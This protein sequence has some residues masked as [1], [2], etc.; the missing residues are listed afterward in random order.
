MCLPLK[1]TSPREV[2]REIKDLQKGKAPGYDLIDATLL[3]ELP[4][5]GIM[6]LVHMFNACLKLEHFPG[7]WKIA[8]VIMIAK[9]GK[10]AQETTSYRP[11]SLLPVVGKLFER[12]L[13]NRMKEHLGTVLPEH[14]FGFRERHGTIEQV[15]RIVDIINRSLENKLYCSAVFLDISQAFDRVWHDGLIHKVKKMLPHC[16]LNILKSYLDNRSYQVKYNEECS[17]LHEIRSGVPQGSILGP[18]LYLVFTADIPTN[19]HTSTATYA[20]DTAILSTHTNPETASLLLQNHLHELELWLKRWRIKANENKSAH[21]TFTL[22]RET[23]PPVKLNDETIP[24]ED[25]AKYLGIHL[26]RRLTW[27]KHIWTKRKQLDGKLRDFRWLIGHQSKLNDNSKLQI[28]KSILKPIWIYGIELW[29]TASNS[30]IDILERF[31]SKTLRTMFGIPQCISNKYIYLD[32]GI[33]TVRQ[34]IAK[35]SLKYQEKLTTHVNKLA[36]TLSGTGGLQYTRLKRHDIPNLVKR[37]P[38]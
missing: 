29:G 1:S 27:Q 33:K 17:D 35:S 12:I 21:V 10:P 38:Q 2:H 28:Y 4:H 18:I 11:I 5:K 26:D 30:N 3:K 13:L 20:D 36:Q 19:E 25:N 6:K 8:Q 31:Q 24:Q 23:C 16:F 15:H 37:F 32:L 14:Q 9:P 22:R 7:Q 34:E